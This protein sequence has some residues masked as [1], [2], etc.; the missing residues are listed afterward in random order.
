MSK[1]LAVT[2][3]NH[4]WQHPIAKNAQ[5]ALQFSVVQKS[6]GWL[7]VSIAEDLIP[8]C[9]MQGVYL[10]VNVLQLIRFCIVGMYGGQALLKQL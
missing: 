1:S 5:I 3:R 10:G 2:A 8:L 6:L 7:M 9:M 4:P